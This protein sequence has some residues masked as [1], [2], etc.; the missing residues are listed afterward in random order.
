M[1]YL[2]WYLTIGLVVLAGATLQYF[3][4]KRRQSDA[5]EDVLDILDP[6]RKKPVN[7][8]LNNFLVPLLSG[9]WV[10]IAWPIVLLLEVKKE[11]SIKEE[12]TFIEVPEFRITS[13]DLLERFSVSQI[14]EREKVN[15]PLGAVPDISFG[16]LHEVWKS[17]IN[18]LTPEDE[19][20]SF[21]VRE[22]R[23]HGKEKRTAGY[24]LVRGKETGK[25]FVAFSKVS[26]KII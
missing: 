22:D 4:E 10:V 21:M 25:Y 9:V 17:F 8:A 15:D 24:V 3:R 14:E 5:L 26:V 2:A 11:F 18:D 7:R 16:F 13:D 19:L 23:P 20:W 1:I 12:S 6:S